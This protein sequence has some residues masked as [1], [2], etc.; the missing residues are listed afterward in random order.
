MRESGEHHQQK[1]VGNSSKH[2]HRKP[3]SVGVST[4]NISEPHEESSTHGRRQNRNLATLEV[5]PGF[6]VT[7]GYSARSAES[8]TIANATLD[9]FFSYYFCYSV[10]DVDPLEGNEIRR[11]F[12]LATAFLRFQVPLD[13]QS[14]KANH[15]NSGHAPSHVHGGLPDPGGDLRLAIRILPAV[16]GGVQNVSAAAWMA[17]TEVADLCR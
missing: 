2:P 16:G 10:I 4:I 14:L 5:T 11:R 13:G 9:C 8:L 12:Q 17:F 3:T 1:T 6:V 7:T 15:Q